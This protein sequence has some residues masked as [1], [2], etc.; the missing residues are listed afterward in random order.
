MSLSDSQK[1]CADRV[2]RLD[3]DRYLSSLFAPDETRPALL[4]LYAFNLEIAT[5]GDNVSETLIG[6]MRLQWWRDALVKL[7]AG[8]DVG[9]GLCLALAE[10]MKIKG[11]P[12]ELLHRMIDCREFDLGDR[13]PANMAEI[14]IY[15]E[16]T[17]VSLMT[18]AIAVLGKARAP[19]DD[20]TRHAGMAMGL[21][22]LIRM[23]P[24]NARHGRVLLPEDLMAE[25]GETREPILAGHT[26]A[27]HG[28]IIKLISE[29]VREHI[30]GVRNIGPRRPELVAI[31]PLSLAEDYLNRLT[32]ADFNPFAPGLEPGRFMRQIRLTRAAWRG[33]V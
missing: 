6:Q 1:F 5:I 16:E 2:R 3:P 32:R 29:R 19:D 10:A 13:S 30:Q 23:I 24:H 28:R 21:T 27:G 15:L 25:E 11:L 12:A 26:H 33:R 7:T 22:G 18:L 8:D 20:L 14:E 9:H 31:L 4:A 17:T